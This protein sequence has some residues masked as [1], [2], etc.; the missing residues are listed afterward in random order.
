MGSKLLV[1]ATGPVRRVAL[2]EDGVTRD[3]IL[4]PRRGRRLVGNIHLGRV[5]RVLPGMQSAFVE[6]GLKRTA[7]LYAG[8]L[9]EDAEAPTAP[10]NERIREGES[11][12]V[13]VAKEPLGTK[14]A[15]ITSNI[16]L[17]GRFLVYMPTVKHVGVSRRIEDE[18]ER[19]RLRDLVEAMCPEQGGLI[20]RTVGEGCDAADFE[21]DLEFL[22]TLW[23]DIE[24]RVKTAKPPSLLHRD[25]D[26]SL[27]AT[28]DL[29]TEDFDALVVDTREEFDR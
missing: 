2:V 5:V 12:L 17:P 16:T 11:L 15:R 19:E 22:T 18:E 25:L 29:L 21:E 28:R 14:G 4:E 20:V 26:L 9:P 7:F 8:D 13:Q 6:I 10:I 1:S 27:M 3:V 24:T 23:K